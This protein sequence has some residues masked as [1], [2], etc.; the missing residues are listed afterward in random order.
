MNASS[1]PHIHGAGPLI[2]ISGI[3]LGGWLHQTLH[4][5]PGGNAVTRSLNVALGA[6]QTLWI[7][8]VHFTELLGSFGDCAGVSRHFFLDMGSQDQTHSASITWLRFIPFHYHHCSL[9]P[10]LS[11]APKLL[12]AVSS[13]PHARE[14][15]HRGLDPASPSHSH[16][17]RA[18]AA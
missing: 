17:Q 4:T 14:Y 15:Q 6:Y 2:L 16:A 12:R 1:R 13:R 9:W 5:A 7:S 3:I 18:C 11:N 10:S 8:L